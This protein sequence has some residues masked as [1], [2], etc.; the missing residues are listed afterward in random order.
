MHE[1][2]HIFKQQQQN[3]K[4]ISLYKIS[5]SLHNEGTNKINY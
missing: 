1:K 4:H 5:H 2:L 3:R